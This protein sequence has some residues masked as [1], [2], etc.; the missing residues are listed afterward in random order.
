[1]TI[2]FILCAELSRYIVTDIYKSKEKLETALSQVKDAEKNKQKYVM[3]VVH[4]LKTPL[5]AVQTYIKSVLQGFLG[6][7]NPQV[8]EKMMRSSERLSEA[9]ALVNSVLKISN[10][11]LLN[12]VQKSDFN[13]TPILNDILLKSKPNAEARKVKIEQDYVSSEIINLYGDGF[14]MRLALSNIISNAIKY[15]HVNGK[16][17]VSL[18]RD[19]EGILIKVTDDGIGIPEAELD[20]IFDEFYR[21]SNSK[22]NF[23]EGTGFGLSLVK[24][25]VEKHDGNISVHSPSGFAI[26]ERPGTEVNIFLP[27]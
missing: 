6:E 26:P 22:L 21:A 1:M 25:I 17:R 20:N 16:V 3:G 18:I 27:F 19:H 12:E 23:I 8:E 14:L 11:K 13:L 24:N 15:N 4:E 2:A 10:L 9:L 5:A 7:V